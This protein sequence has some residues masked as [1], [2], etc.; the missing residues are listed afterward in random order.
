MEITVFDSKGR[1][2]TMAKKATSTTSVSAA[3]PAPAP[4]KKAAAPR[5]KKHVKAQ[6]AEPVTVEPEVAV[7]SVA[8]AVTHEDISRLAYQFYLERKG[9]NGSPAEDWLRAEQALAAR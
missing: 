2:T 1:F 9:Q 8:I 7:E 6:V 5:A 4:V 3:A